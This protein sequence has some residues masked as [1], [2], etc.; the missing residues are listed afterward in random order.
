MLL[1]FLMLTGMIAGAS[2][3]LLLRPEAAVIEV[4]PAAR[5]KPGMTE[6]RV[7]R[8]LGERAGRTILIGGCGFCRPAPKDTVYIRLYMRSKVIVLY[9]SGKVTKVGSWE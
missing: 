5:I 9:E 7:E 1:P 4:A 6:I 3:G 2:D 8:V